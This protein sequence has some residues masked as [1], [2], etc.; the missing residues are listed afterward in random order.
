MKTILLHV[1]DDAG[2]P[3]RLDS[4][5]ALARRFG[6]RLLCVQVAPFGVWPG[7]ALP[8]FD[9]GGIGLTALVDS[10]HRLDRRARLAVEQRLASAAIAWDWRCCEGDVADML[11][12]QAALV[13]LIILSQ[14]LAGAL[15][16][17]GGPDPHAG[18]VGEVAV[19]ARAAVLVVPAD[20]PALAPAIAAGGSVLVAWNG[21]AEAAFALR[22]ARPL[23]AQAGAIHLVTVGDPGPGIT[24]TAAAGWL[25]RH[26]LA[27]DIH[28]WPAK[29]RRIS[30]ALLNAATE[31]E[32]ALLVMGA[33]GHS[34][35]RETVLGGVTR[36]IIAMAPLPL[37][38][39]H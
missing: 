31:L 29:G 28:D 10:R 34:R 36:E 6:A 8:G 25:A 5:I 24:A 1:H 16:A 35:L 7:A 4:A 22:L 17:A 9:G 23:L 39:A 38:L 33:Y 3:R 27:A 12:E 15:S 32:V 20:L 11:V 13:D 14:P 30:A 18:L 19:N 37:L 2:L 21:S 26:G